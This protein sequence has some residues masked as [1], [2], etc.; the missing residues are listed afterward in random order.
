MSV[1]TSMLVTAA[2]LGEADGQTAQIALWHYVEGISQG[3]IA[4]LAGVSRVTVNQRLKRFREQAQRFEA[5][6]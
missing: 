2:I 3:E 1:R 6:L 5:A 4:K